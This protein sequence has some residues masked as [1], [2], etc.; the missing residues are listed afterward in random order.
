MTKLTLEQKFKDNKV[1]PVL[2][3]NLEDGDFLYSHDCDML[4]LI[5]LNESQDS[6]KIVDLSANLIVNTVGCFEHTFCEYNNR[7]GPFQVVKKAKLT[8]KL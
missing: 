6:S 2:P 3:E 7:F 8:F 1:K 5:V 4:L